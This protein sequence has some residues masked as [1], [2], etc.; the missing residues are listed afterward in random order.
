MHSRPAA[1]GVVPPSGARPGFEGK[2]QTFI[3]KKP[4]GKGAHPA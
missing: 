3:N 2:K 4:K 1:Q